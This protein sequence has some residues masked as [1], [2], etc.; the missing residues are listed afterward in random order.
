MRALLDCIEA[1][2]H[3]IGA[4]E[5]DFRRH[6]DLLRFL[7]LVVVVFEILRVPAPAKP[8]IRDLLF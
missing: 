8:R 7:K 6:L 4:G 5:P 1:L 3:H 2:E